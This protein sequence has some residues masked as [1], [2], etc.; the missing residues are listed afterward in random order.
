MDVQLNAAGKR[1]QSTTNRRLA[2][3]ES[4]ALFA[5]AVLIAATVSV[6]RW[7]VAELLVIAAFT[8]ASTLMAVDSCT[9]RDALSGGFLD[10]VLPRCYWAAVPRL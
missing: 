8:V 7:N 3:A 6:D 1:P 10:V 2:A 5:A 4:A 9:G